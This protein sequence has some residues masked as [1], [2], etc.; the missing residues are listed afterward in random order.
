MKRYSLLLVRK[1]RGG[2]GREVAEIHIIEVEEDS[3]KKVTEMH[4]SGYTALRRRQ[5]IE[6]GKDGRLPE[7][8]FGRGFSMQTAQ[9]TFKYP[10]LYSNGSYISFYIF[11]SQR[12]YN[13][14]KEL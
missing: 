3:L 13:I 7:V 9:R 10:A 14:I 1:G 12:M 5:S 6:T 2:E 4:D 8:G 11:Q